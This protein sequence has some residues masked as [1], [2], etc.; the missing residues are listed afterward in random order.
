MSVSTAKTYNQ[1]V[2]IICTALYFYIGHSNL[3]NFFC[4]QARA[5]LRARLRFLIWNSSF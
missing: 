2:C 5:R 4:T 3:C 1:Q